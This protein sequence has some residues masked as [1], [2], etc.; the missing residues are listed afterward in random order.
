MPSSEQQLPVCVCMYNVYMCTCIKGLGFL[1]FL[2]FDF[3]FV[4]SFMKRLGGLI[5]VGG[6]IENFNFNTCLCYLVFLN[7][8]SIH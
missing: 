3:L 2:H 5:A 8:V 4:D 7:W 1:A 6:T